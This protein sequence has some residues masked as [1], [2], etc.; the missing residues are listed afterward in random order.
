V[1]VFF[2]FVFTGSLGAAGYLARDFVGRKIAFPPEPPHVVLK[3][4]PVWMSDL[5]AEE[6]VRAAKPAGAHSAFDHQVLVD[7]DRILRAS[8]W[9]RDVRQVRR[10]YQ[11]QPG[12]TIE[13]DCDYR[14]PVALVEWGSYYWLVDGEG[15]KLPAQFTA[16]QLNHVVYGADHKMNIRVIRGVQ[17]PPVNAG[18]KWGGDDLQAGLDMLKTLYGQSF[19]EEIVSVDVSNYDHRQSLRNAQLTL[20][21]VRN[22]QIHWGT[23]INGRTEFEIPTARKLENLKLIYA[24]CGR[25]DAVHEELDIRLDNP[26]F[27]ST[28]VVQ[29]SHQ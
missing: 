25:V 21:T 20:W 12:D 23:P 4:R 24:K 8:P 27:P 26:T 19:A 6:I 28:D 17:S 16:G 29:T 13:I 2:A 10:V 3:N 18:N 9:I 1:H 15:V 14:A 5:L 7:I 11:D 22:T